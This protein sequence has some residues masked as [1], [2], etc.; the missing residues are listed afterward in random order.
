MK[1]GVGYADDA[2]ALDAGRRAAAEAMQRGGVAAPDLVVAFCAGPVDAQGFLSGVRA[3][4][5]PRAP[6]LGGSAVGVITNEAL[7][8][9]GT[10]SA[11]A[12]LELG[13]ALRGV[14]AVDRVDAD[15]RA[16]G[17]RMGR[18]LGEAG[19]AAALLLFYDSIRT[20][21]TASTPPV[22]NASRPL[23]AGIAEGLPGC[24]P[25]VGAGVLGDFAFSPTWQFCGDGARRQHAAG[26]LLAASARPCVQ[27][28]HG[29]TPMDGV[30]HVLTRVEG[31]VIHEIDGRPAAERI[32]DVYG[33]RAWRSQ[34][35]VNRLALGVPQLERHRLA[36]EDGYVNRL[37]TG[38]LPD[39]KAVGL[40]EPDL[41]DGLEV[42]FM[43]RDPALMIASARAGS[44]AAVERMRRD[45]G[46]P[47]FALYVDCAGR[48]AAVSKTTSEEAAEVQ[49]VMNREGVSLLGFYSGVEVAP[50]RGQSR[51]LDWTGVLLLLGDG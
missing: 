7:R 33:S 20:P 41:E 4:V 25:V 15:E 36:G 30:P 10:P 35:P 8:Y 51:G 48:A 46:R 18:M 29:C 49:A 3:A 38:V 42:L 50:L 34:R 32:D 17:R 6:I 28:M 24:P 26:A 27:V 45:G 14:A 2:G 9:E 1:A 47:R 21:A 13:G 16:A 44:E 22:M 12:V 39:G 31:D 5:G 40:F 19:D 11:V 23:I 43:L 37:I